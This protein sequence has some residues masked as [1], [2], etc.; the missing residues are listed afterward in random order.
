MT[1]QPPTA[2][3]ASAVGPCPTIIQISAEV[4]SKFSV[5]GHPTNFYS[6][7]ARVGRLVV[8]GLTAL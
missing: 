8:L 4:L 2:P 3:T 6:S 1:K 7:R 5:P